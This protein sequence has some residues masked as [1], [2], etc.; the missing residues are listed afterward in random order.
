MA[1]IDSE[2]ALT[3]DSRAVHAGR[4]D[5]AALGVHAAPLDLSTTN[6]LPDI[7]SGGDSL[8][9]MAGGGHPT[10]AGGAVYARVW[11]P[12]VA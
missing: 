6:P 2:L 12:T 11:N 7:E 9:A 5:L 1:T 3:L 10:A 8:E 4:E